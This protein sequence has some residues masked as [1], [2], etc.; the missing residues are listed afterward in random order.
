MYRFF[1]TLLLFCCL[2]G[3]TERNPAPTIFPFGEDEKIVVVNY[4]AEW[5][6][7]CREE[8]PELNEFQ[9]R[10]AD[11]VWLFGVNFDGVEGE[12][13]SELEKNMGIEFPTLAADPGPQMG[14]SLPQG[15]PYTMVTDGRGERLIRLPG[16][17]TIESLEAALDRFRQLGTEE[18]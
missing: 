2:A 12:A 14:W 13:L 3:C 5:C 16:K 7:P 8:I 11:D 17:Q 1:C 9:E 15:L 18:M 10:F 6:K 4:W